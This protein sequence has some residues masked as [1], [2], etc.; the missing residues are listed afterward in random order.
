[1]AWGMQNPVAQLRSM[2][3]RY[4]NTAKLGVRVRQVRALGGAGTYV[5]GVNGQRA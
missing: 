1:M 4:R 3:I 2:A 5:C